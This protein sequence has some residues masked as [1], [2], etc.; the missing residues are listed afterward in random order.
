MVADSHGMAARISR[1]Y[2]T[3]WTRLDRQNPAR[4]ALVW[5]SIPQGGSVQDTNFVSAFNVRG[6]ARPVHGH[7]EPPLHDDRWS[8]RVRTG[9]PYWCHC[10][11]GSRAPGTGDG[12]EADGH[13]SCGQAAEATH[14]RS[15]RS[16]PA[17]TADRGAVAV[18][19]FDDSPSA[20]GD[21][22]ARRTQTDRRIGTG[23]LHP[24]R[25]HD[26]VAALGDT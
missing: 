24:G 7:G 10:S 17:L 5:G 18:T 8:H 9:S 21:Q 14:I 13:R 15:G 6:P 12:M 25:V 1:G 3:A 16:C 4:N 23:G 20:G 19:E 11:M 22:Q 2:G 26:L